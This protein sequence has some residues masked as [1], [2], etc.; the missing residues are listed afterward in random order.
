MKYIVEHRVPSKNE[1]H[2]IGGKIYTAKTDLCMEKRLTILLEVPEVDLSEACKT[3]ND[4]I[5]YFDKQLS[6]D[7]IDEARAEYTADRNSLQ[8]AITILKTLN[9]KQ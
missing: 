3:L 5:G 9:I 7:L 2:F 4:R 1:K 6:M 8:Q